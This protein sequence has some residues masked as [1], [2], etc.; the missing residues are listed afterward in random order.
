M[1][2][3]HLVLNILTTQFNLLVLLMQEYVYVENINN[4]VSNQR[5]QILLLSTRIEEKDAHIRKQCAEL[6]AANDELE[7]SNTIASQWHHEANY[8]K[9]STKITPEFYSQLSFEEREDLLT[10]ILKDYSAQEYIQR[11]CRNGT[12]ERWF[13][14]S[15]VT[16]EKLQT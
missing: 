6:K 4:H 8:V 11:T 3:Y 1:I 15:G 9:N 2:F 12:V 10:Y 16:P 5:D 7:R 13:R 14:L